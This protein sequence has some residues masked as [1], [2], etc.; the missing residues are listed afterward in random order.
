MVV[1][2]FQKMPHERENRQHMK[3]LDRYILKTDLSVSVD[4]FTMHDKINTDLKEKHMKSVYLSYP[5]SKPIVIH[6]SPRS[7]KG[8]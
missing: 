8:R 5:E 3:C 4:Y 7:L 1:D 2:C 6:L